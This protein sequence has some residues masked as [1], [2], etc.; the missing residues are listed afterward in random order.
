MSEILVSLCAAIC[1]AEGWH[2]VEDFGK[3]KI[4]FLR[5]VLAYKNG[6]PSDDT[7]RRFFRSLNVETF[8]NLFREWV[9]T[10][11][12]KSEGSVIAI[13]DKSSRYSFDTDTKMLHMISAYSIETRLVLAQ[14]K[15][16]EKSNEITIIPRLLK[17]LDLKHN[18]VTI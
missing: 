2:D 18:I 10:I 16:S 17:W 3:A 6:I 13:D 8:E 12:P 14:E 15:V 1:G 9:N 5:K 4:D 11:Y 7:F